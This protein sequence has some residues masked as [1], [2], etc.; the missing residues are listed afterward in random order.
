MEIHRYNHYPRQKCLQFE[1]CNHLPVFSFD[2]GFLVGE[3]QKDL[4]DELIL[5]DDRIS[6]EHMPFERISPQREMVRGAPVD[7]F[8]VGGSNAA[9]AP[10]MVACRCQKASETQNVIVAVGV[11]VHSLQQRHLLDIGM[12]PVLK[13][14]KIDVDRTADIHHVIAKAFAFRIKGGFDIGCCQFRFVFRLMPE[15]ETVVHGKVLRMDRLR[16]VLQ[17]VIAFCEQ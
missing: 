16:I 9:S 5:F 12:D 4:C 2:D 13:G 6:V 8:T 3:G 7:D 17:D 14:F 10:D 15:E 1:P 11:R